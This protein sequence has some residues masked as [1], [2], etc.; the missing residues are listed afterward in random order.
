VKKIMNLLACVVVLVACSTAYSETYI[1]AVALEDTAVGAVSKNTIYYNLREAYYERGNSAP[2]FDDFN[3]LGEVD[4]RACTEVF[5]KDPDNPLFIAV[6]LF[7][8]HHAAQGPL[9]PARSIKKVLVMKSPRIQSNFDKFTMEWA[10]EFLNSIYEL[11]DNNSYETHIKKQENLL[12][13]RR[14]GKERGESFISYGYYY[15]L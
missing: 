9:I 1:E 7:V 15:Y 6:N 10:S 11:D 5:S 12:I 8:E 13:F 14:K 2:V 4:A 3:K